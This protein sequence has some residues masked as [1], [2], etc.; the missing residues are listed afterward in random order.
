M[1]DDYFDINDANVVCRQGGYVGATQYHTSAYYGRGSGP[2]WFDDL[3]CYGT[4]TS[5]F[6]CHHRGIG[7]HNCGHNEDVG[8]VCEGIT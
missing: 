7:S 2:I 1:C 5:L 3:Y 8:V 4:E 6:D